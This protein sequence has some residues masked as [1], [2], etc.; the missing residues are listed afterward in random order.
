MITF[1]A[2]WLKS[3]NLYAVLAILGLAVAIYV[4]GDRHR[5]RKIASE[6]A[7]TNV[8]LAHLRGKTEAELTAEESTAKA[9]DEAVRKALSK[10]FVLDAE[11]AR[12]LSSV[13]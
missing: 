13:K 7:E 9:V 12:L 3:A 8:P 11:T 1:L 10:R 5:A 6:V 4:A 2:P